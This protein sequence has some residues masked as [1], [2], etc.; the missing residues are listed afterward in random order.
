MKR[1]EI[2]DAIEEI[3]GNNSKR[4]VG[5]NE[6]ELW[7]REGIADF[8]LKLLAEKDAEIER[9]KALQMPEHIC[10][11]FLLFDDG[12]NKTLSC[13]TCGKTKKK[14]IANEKY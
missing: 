3:Q 1:Y 8:V 5:V 7:T 9:L 11:T 4:F 13:A 12:E 14:F 2:I 6:A 10:T